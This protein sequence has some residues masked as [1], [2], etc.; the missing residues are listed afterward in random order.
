L[1]TQLASRLRGVTGGDVL[2]DLGRLLPDSPALPVA[3][4]ADVVLVVASGS[5]EGVVHARDRVR[6]LVPVCAG[7]LGVVVVASDRRGPRALEALRAVLDRD[8]L[9]AWVAGFVAVD[10]A[11]VTGLYAGDG[12]A[13]QRRTLLARTTRVVT[14]VVAD[15]L[16]APAEPAGP[17]EP[18]QP[19]TT[20]AVTR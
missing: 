18:T 5:V 15:W 14:S 11:G 12:S 9:P 8:G 16:T 10:S 3:A 17:R 2:A 7:R 4:A 13:R 6:A 19:R 20:S 1:W